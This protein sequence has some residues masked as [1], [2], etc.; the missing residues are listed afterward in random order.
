MPRVPVP[1]RG[2]VRT[3][4][5]IHSGE[6]VVSEASKGSMHVLKL[7][8]EDITHTLGFLEFHLT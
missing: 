3:C 8:Q 4:L 5:N 7:A 6:E 1:Y 2:R